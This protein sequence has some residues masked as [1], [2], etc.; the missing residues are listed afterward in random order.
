M[1]DIDFVPYEQGLVKSDYI[2]NPDMEAYDSAGD[3]INPALL[4]HIFQ[5]GSW[6]VLQVMPILFVNLFKI[7]IVIMN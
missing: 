3:L 7:Y 4:S 6:A 1:A 2:V 5:P